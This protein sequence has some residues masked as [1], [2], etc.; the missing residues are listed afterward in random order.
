M[1]KRRGAGASQ[2]QLPFLI[3][4]IIITITA[5]APATCTLSLLLVQY[6]VTRNPC[7]G[8][9]RTRHY[10][11]PRTRP[12]TLPFCHLPPPAPPLPLPSATMTDSTYYA[13]AAPLIIFFALFRCFRMA[14]RH[15]ESY[16][17]QSRV[18]TA[19]AN[20]Q[21][22]TDELARATAARDSVFVSNCAPWAKGARVNP[23]WNDAV[24]SF[25]GQARLQTLHRALYNAKQ[26]KDAQGKS[27]STSSAQADAVY[28]AL[29]QL[30]AVITWSPDE[31]GPLAAAGAAALVVDALLSFPDSIHA[32][33][34]A[35]TAL[36][37]LCKRDLRVQTLGTPATAQA[38]S[39][40]LALCAGEGRPS[41]VDSADDSGDP[42][43]VAKGVTSPVSAPIAQLLYFS[44]AIGVIAACGAISGL[45][46]I[47][48]FE[49]VL[50]AAAGPTLFLILSSTTAMSFEVATAVARAL[51]VISWNS[52][53]K[54][55]LNGVGGVSMCLSFVSYSGVT[56]WPGA[57]TDDV[58]A[59]LCRLLV[60]NDSTV[61]AAAATTFATGG[62]IELSTRKLST[63]L[64]T[65]NVKLAT[66]GAL[67]IHSAAK[68]STLRGKYAAAGVPSSLLALL[69][70]FKDP[71]AVEAAANAL[72]RLCIETPIE[73]GVVAEVGWR[74]RR[75]N[76]R[77]RLCRVFPLTRVPSHSLLGCSRAADFH[78]HPRDGRPPVTVRAALPRLHRRARVQRAKRELVRGGKVG[79]VRAGGGGVGPPG[80]G[81]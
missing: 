36:N 39:R 11:Q 62:G 40:A 50:A 9:Y 20:L 37:V 53:S 81:Q 74:G 49:Q 38:V 14:N 68:S 30:T 73:E 31:A 63:G 28:D 3:I 1:P 72:G 22:A 13:V 52:T 75:N 33:R 44:D 47:D 8:P 32:A 18:H 29:V 24:A 26:V 57:A 35:C 16:A 23:P 70:Q 12:R 17:A 61:E 80:A 60:N 41:V 64:Q 66:S 55:S 45:G 4:I 7:T 34:V 56:R 46:F 58:V 10:H 54:A 21:A 15:S 5:R 25:V 48:N 65:N 76:L 42:T 77:N 69:R 67:L 6:P 19:S 79:A 43:S 2:K 27:L 51:D 78:P 59:V 71:A